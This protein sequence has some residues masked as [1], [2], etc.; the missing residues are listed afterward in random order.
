LGEDAVVDQQVHGSAGDGTRVVDEAR[1]VVR[2]GGRLILVQPNFPLNPPGY[3]DDFTDVS[4]FTDCSLADYLTSE[5]WTVEGVVP[6]LLPP[7]D[8]IACG[9]A[10]VHGSLVSQVTHQ[11]P[12]RSDARHRDS[13]R[14]LERDQQHLGSASRQ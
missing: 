1:W 13:Q 2:A 10:V 6:A 12:R 5:G 8:E 4:I 3:F 7:D 11:A 14:R 9:H